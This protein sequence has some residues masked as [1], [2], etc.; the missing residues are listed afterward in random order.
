MPL[1]NSTINAK[2]MPIELSFDNSVTWKTLVCL[3]NISIPLNTPVTEEETYCGTK[4]GVG[5]VKFNPSGEAVCET[6]P[7][8]TEVSFDDLLEKMNAGTS[9]LWR[10]QNPTSGSVGVGLYL[11]GSC[12]CTDLE[13]TGEAGGLVNFT[14]TLT[15][16]GTLTTTAP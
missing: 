15:G 7:S 5:T 8:A 12:K 3:K 4:V 13:L 14:F 1:T 16:E 10:V 11:S 6:R 9:F 2:D